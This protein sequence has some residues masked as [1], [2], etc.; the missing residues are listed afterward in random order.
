MNYNEWKSIYKKIMKDFDFNIED[1]EESACILD[2]FINMNKKFCSIKKIENVIRNK[3]IVIFG[4]GP[5]LKNSILKYHERFED[6]FKIAADG[7]T[8]A[9]LENDYLPDVIVTDL[10][11]RIS[12][13]IKASSLGSIIVLHAH[14]DN[15]KKINK[16]FEKF[17]G[18][19][20]GTT[21]INPR[22][23]VNLHN[24]GGFT[25][26]D[27]AVFLADHLHA[28]RIFLIGFDFTGKI[29]KYSFAKNK[30][31]ELKMKKL[32]WCKYLI[33]ELSKQIV[34]NFL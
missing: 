16:Y 12:D 29:G 20:I 21:H 27:R 28:R 6:N 18:D 1:E 30:D 33:D 9:L 31:K 14:G 23:Y 11:G 15:I 25:D 3:D 7:A 32:K 24:F 8:T 5:S 19:L 22:S 26:G 17:K 10:D 13:Q 34:I 2:S 4:A